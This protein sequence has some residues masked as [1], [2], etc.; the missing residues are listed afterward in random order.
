MLT[1]EEVAASQPGSRR[2]TAVEGSLISRHGG[3]VRYTRML[4]QGEPLGRIVLAHGFLRSRERL[5]GWAQWLASHGWETAVPTFVHSHLL[6]GNHSKNAEDLRD[7]ADSLWPNQGRLYGGFSAGGLAALLAASEDPLAQGWVGLDPV[8]SGGLARPAGAVL[9][10]RGLRSL[11]FLAESGPCNA[12]NN[13]LMALPEDQ[14]SVWLHRLPGATHHALE[15]PF[16]PS[17]NGLCGQ[18][19]PPEAVTA[20][21]AWVRSRWLTWLA[22][23]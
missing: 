22:T 4:P 23:F 9:Q 5:I 1:G 18:M 13:V 21:Q 3:E 12:E 6:A 2:W 11:V 20:V 19:Q 10:R 16:D 15:D 17:L 8:D 7:L 14:D